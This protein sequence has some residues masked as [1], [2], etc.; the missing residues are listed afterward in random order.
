[1]IR[2]CKLIAYE[3]A[4][5]IIAAVASTFAALLGLVPFFAVARMATAIYASPPRLEV[6]EQLAWWTA[7]ALL[8]RYALVWTATM[9]AHVAAYRVL[10]ALRFDLAKKLGAVPLSFF[11]RNPS[12]TLKKTLMDDVNGV[13]A[14]V[15]H[16]FPDAVA[17]AIVPLAT[18]IALTWVDWRM[19]L[20]SIAV[21]PLAV[22]AMMVAMRDVGAAHAHWNDIQ[23][24][25]NN[26]VLDYFRG[27]HVIKSFGLTAKRFGD[28]SRSIEDG[29]AWMQ[30]FMRTNGRGY[31]AFAALIGSSLVVLV[32]TGGW[33]YAQGSLTLESLVLFLVLGPQLLMSMMRL[34]FAW[35][36]IDRIKQGVGRIDAVL[37]TREALVTESAAQ[38]RNHGIVFDDVGFRYGDDGAPV[39]QN[40]TFAAAPGKVTALVGPSGAGKTTLARLVPRLWEATSGRVAVGE[41]NVKSLKL[42]DLTARVSMV[43]Q[44][45]FLFHGTVRDNLRLARAHATDAQ[46]EAACRAAAAHDFIMALPHGYETLLGER[47]ARLSGGERQR[48]S[49]AR[50]LLK[51]APIVLLDEATAFADAENEA[52]IQE[53]LSR[54]CVGR[55][56]L[57]IAHRLSTIVHADHIVVLDKGRIVDQ[58]RHDELL[59]CPLYQTLWRS[60]NDAKGWRMTPTARAT[61]STTTEATL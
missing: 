49:I 31:G 38:P 10:H 56:V 32:P 4:L 14:F 28:L 13:E 34:M 53:G 22:V 37:G 18:A 57:V 20:A 24:R 5:L 47:G 19:A 2:I 3:P 59:C 21:A 46:V 26:A 6:V 8:G 29:L 9:T 11:S 33:L 52:R 17:A 25:M 39:L 7:G 30:G 44:D 42:E 50:A 60:H 40:V 41:V 23:T 15:A 54:L 12:G 51:D 58:G 1:M 55:T 45:V 43:F 35:G 36:N 61:T 16:N 48:L 27:I